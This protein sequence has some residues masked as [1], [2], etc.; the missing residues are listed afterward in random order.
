MDFGTLTFMIQHEAQLRAAADERRA[1][2]TERYAPLP[3]MTR[4]RSQ[5]GRWRRADTGYSVK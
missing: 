5:K 2:D 4:R 1:R 3:D